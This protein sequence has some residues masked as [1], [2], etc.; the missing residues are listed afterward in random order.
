MQSFLIR[1]PYAAR[2]SLK[3]SV[4]MLCPL[5][6]FRIRIT[7]SRK[8]AFPW[9]HA[10][11]NAARSYEWIKTKSIR[12]LFEELATGRFLAEGRNASPVEAFFSTTSIAFVELKLSREKSRS[13]GGYVK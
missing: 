8:R 1:S 4:R 6:Q 2:S 10:F 3:M 12:T 7:K 11:D 9:A 13:E 5:W